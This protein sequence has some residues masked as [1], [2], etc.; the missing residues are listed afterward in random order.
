MAGDEEEYYYRATPTRTEIEPLSEGQVELVVRA[1]VVQ[2]WVMR[3]TLQGA[4]A[5]AVKQLKKDGN[6]K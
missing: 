4:T 3:S 1:L 5:D 6:L 2:G